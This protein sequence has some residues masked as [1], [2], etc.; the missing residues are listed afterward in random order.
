MISSTPA[1]PP[2]KR[3]RLSN[4]YSNEASASIQTPTV[5]L[6]LSQHSQNLLAQTHAMKA[7]PQQIPLHRTPLRYPNFTPSRPHNLQLMARNTMQC[8]STSTRDHLLNT[9]LHHHIN[10]NRNS[11]QKIATAQS[12]VTNNDIIDLSE[13]SRDSEHY[14]THNNIGM[15]ANRCRSNINLKKNETAVRSTRNERNNETNYMNHRNNND[16][17]TNKNKYKKDTSNNNNC[18]NGNKNKSKNQSIIG[19]THQVKTSKKDLKTYHPNSIDMGLATGPIESQNAAIELDSNVVTG[20]AAVEQ[21]QATYKSIG[22][23]KDNP[24]IIAPTF[25][26]SDDNVKIVCANNIV[27]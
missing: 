1:H 27:I 19:N 2:K 6:S 13:A 23:Q 9:S 16:K 22:K 14:N 15:N 25:Q 5:N 18:N 26:R 4:P 12:F 21:V 10:T 17:S 3:V 11:Q 8:H 24:V 20:I 7:P